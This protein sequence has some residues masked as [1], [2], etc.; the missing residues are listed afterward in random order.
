MTWIVRCMGSGLGC[1]LHHQHFIWNTDVETGSSS[2]R[3][4]KWLL[5]MLTW[6]LHI[7]IYLNG[8]K[9]VWTSLFWSTNQTSQAFSGTSFW[10]LPFV[11]HLNSNKRETHLETAIYIIN[12]DQGVFNTGIRGMC[13]FTAG[14]VYSAALWSLSETRSIVIFSRRGFVLQTVYSSFLFFPLQTFDESFNREPVIR[15]VLAL[16]DPQIHTVPR[17]LLVWIYAAFIWTNK[18]NTEGIQFI[19]LWWDVHNFNL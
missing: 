2:E 9:T 10:S 16:T 18:C 7:Y 15:P 3:V 4:T 8:K 13:V 14:V 19:F 1:V 6:L 5:L 17:N 11:L 12:S